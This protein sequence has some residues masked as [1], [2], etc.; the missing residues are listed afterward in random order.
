MN[1]FGALRR[2]HSLIKEGAANPYNHYGTTYQGLYEPIG[3]R[4]IGTVVDC[5]K[6]NRYPPSS[7]IVTRN[8]ELIGATNQFV[9]RT[10]GWIFEIDFDTPF[11]PNDILHERLGVFAL[12][13]LGCRNTLNVDGAVQL[14]FVREVTSPTET[15]LVIDFSDQGNS[16]QYRLDGWHGQEPE[17]IWTNGTSSTMSIAF[18]KPGQRYKLEI[19]AW[20]FVAPPKLPDQ[21]LMISVGDVQL[22][23]M[24]VRPGLNFLECEI[25][26]EHTE[27]P[28]TTLHFGLPDAVRACDFH[29]G[30]EQRVLA[31]AVRRITLKRCLP[32]KMDEFG[33]KLPDPVSP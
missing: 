8:N 19:L 20:P 10:N 23:K 1:L 3:R 22:T 21:T 12:D 25:S 2:L 6:L 17:Q 4:I 32:A 13:R 33:N 14:S 7:V 9:S 5:S 30:A 16:A 18:D 26:P 31:L 27:T 24:Y 15:E 11:T 28:Q 29:P